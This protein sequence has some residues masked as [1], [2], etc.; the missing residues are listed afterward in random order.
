MPMMCVSFLC[1]GTESPVL[2]VIL[3][4]MVKAHFQSLR[5]TSDSS[6]FSLCAH[7]YCTDDTKSDGHIQ[8][9]NF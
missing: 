5:L 4:K 9:R 3:S 2:A 1:L 6:A 7:G 8:V